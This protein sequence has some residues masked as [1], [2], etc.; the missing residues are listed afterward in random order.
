MSRREYELDA[1]VGVWLGILFVLA[2]VLTMC[3]HG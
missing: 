3:G 2:L 1:L